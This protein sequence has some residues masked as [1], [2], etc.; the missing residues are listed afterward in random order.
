MDYTKQEEQSTIVHKNEAP[1]S[2]KF[3]PAG[4]RMKLYFETT[5]EL[6]VKIQELKKCGLI[7]PLMFPQIE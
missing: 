4:A 2:F 1:N 3:G 6:V 5:E 7:D